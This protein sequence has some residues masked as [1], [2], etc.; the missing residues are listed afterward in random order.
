M[1]FLVDTHLLLWA[2]ITPQKLSA[3]ARVFLEDG[4]NILWFSAVSILE[5]AIKQSL[6]RSEFRIDPR[7]LRAGLFQMGYTELPLEGRQAL[8]LV[9]MPYFHTDP[10]DRLL[11]AQARSEGMLLLTADKQLSAYG[12]FVELV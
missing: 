5:V 4:K 7:P 6:K 11:V 10:F 12:D 8:D 9:D 2:S 1:N 3:K